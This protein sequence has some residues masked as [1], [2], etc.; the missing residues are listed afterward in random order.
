MSVLQKIQRRRNSEVNLGGETV[1]IQSLSYYDGVATDSI[2]ETPL[3]VYYAIGSCLLEDDGKPTFP[4]AEGETPVEFAKR[5]QAATKD[6]G[7]EVVTA[8]SEAISK[9]TKPP[10]VKAIE[11]N[12]ETTDSPAS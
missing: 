4:K 12:S 11:K 6:M 1:R 3:K 10:T 5:V 7:A 8:L 2:S 9:L